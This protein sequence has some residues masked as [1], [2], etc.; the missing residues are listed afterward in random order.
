VLSG[1]DDFFPIQTAFRINGALV[2]KKCVKV[3]AGV[4]WRGVL[5]IIQLIDKRP[6]DLE[7]QMRVK[8]WLILNRKSRFTFSARVKIKATVLSWRFS[9]RSHFIGLHFLYAYEEIKKIL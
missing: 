8:T 4:K 6:R 3:S 7:R 9:L 5:E 1:G 2:V